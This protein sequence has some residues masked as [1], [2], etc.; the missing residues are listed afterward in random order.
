[1]C[2]CVCCCVCVCVVICVCVYDSDETIEIEWRLETIKSPIQFCRF[3]CHSGFLFYFLTHSLTLDFVL[4]R[5]WSLSPLCDKTEFQLNMFGMNISSHTVLICFDVSDSSLDRIS[6]VIFFS[7]DQRN[8]TKP[9]ISYLSAKKF[10]GI[11]FSKI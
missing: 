4:E 8:V 11:K 2:V 9:R 1:M 7:P 6:C 10:K 5:M 3:S